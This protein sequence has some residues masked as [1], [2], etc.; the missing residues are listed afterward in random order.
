M[1]VAISRRAGN[2]EPVAGA[3]IMAS[4]FQPRRFVP[5]REIRIT[6]ATLPMLHAPFHST[7]GRSGSYQRMSG[8]LSILRLCAF[9]LADFVRKCAGIGNGAH[10]QEV[11]ADQTA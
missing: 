11:S 2:L 7:F 10:I 9:D 6:R 8:Q 1:I 5:P 3:K 4:S